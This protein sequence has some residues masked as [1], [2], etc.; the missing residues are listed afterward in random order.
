MQMSSVVEIVDLDLAFLG[1][2]KI[3]HV[4][5]QIELGLGLVEV[6]LVQGITGNLGG[7]QCQ[8]DQRVVMDAKGSN[9][10]T[11]LLTV[12]SLVFV[13]CRESKVIINKIIYKL[14]QVNIRQKSIQL[15][16]TYITDDLSSTFGSNNRHSIRLKVVALSEDLLNIFPV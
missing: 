12:P 4:D 14:A 9:V 3:Q 5:W 11:N 13:L 16:V 7:V 2:F 15:Y 10:V 6:F 1:Q 8:H